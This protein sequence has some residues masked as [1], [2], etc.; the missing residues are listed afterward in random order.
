MTAHGDWELITP[1]NLPE[2]GDL[3]LSSSCAFVMRV[4]FRAKHSYEEWTN[5]ETNDWKWKAKLE[6]PREIEEANWKNV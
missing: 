2:F 5:P 1:E 4:M 6:L 3:V